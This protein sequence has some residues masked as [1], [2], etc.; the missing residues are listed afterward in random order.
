MTWPWGGCSFELRD[1]SCFECMQ[2]YVYV[3]YKLRARLFLLTRSLFSFFKIPLM[4]SVILCRVSLWTSRLSAKLIN[5]IHVQVNGGVALCS[6][7][8]LGKVK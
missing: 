8:S 6:G 4:C 5:N 3:C 1:S 2:V 7:A